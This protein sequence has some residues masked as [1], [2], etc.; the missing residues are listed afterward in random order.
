MTTENKERRREE[1]CF[2]REVNIAFVF[3]FVF[4][5]KLNIILTLGAWFI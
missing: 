1:E 2:R 5:Q 4:F 3:V